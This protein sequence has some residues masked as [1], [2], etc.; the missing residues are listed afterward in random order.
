[1]VITRSDGWRRKRERERKARDIKVRKIS[2][3]SERKETT[4]D[5]FFSF[6]FPPFCN[7]YHYLGG[8]VGERL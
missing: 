6:F 7:F 3:G 8:E 2:Q 5:F 1:M 4:S